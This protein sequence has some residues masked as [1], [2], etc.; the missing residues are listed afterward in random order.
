MVTWVWTTLRRF[1]RPSSSLSCQKSFPKSGWDEFGDV[2]DEDVEF[3]L[4]VR[5][6]S[7]RFFTWAASV[8]STT[9]AMPWPPRAVTMSGGF[10]DGFGAA[11]VVERRDFFV[12]NAGDAIG[13]GAAAGAV[14]GGAGLAEGEGDAAAEAAGGAGDEGDAAF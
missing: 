10:V 13:G 9:A 2:V 3:F 4:F 11:R 6:R 14:D 5:M 1:F 12:G 7:M 8:W